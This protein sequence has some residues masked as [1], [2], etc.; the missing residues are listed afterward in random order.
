M[1]L[2]TAAEV[3][4]TDASTSVKH[5][6]AVQVVVHNHVDGE[7]GDGS[8]IDQVLITEAVAGEGELVRVVDVHEASMLL[9][10]A[11]NLLLTLLE[12]HLTVCKNDVGFR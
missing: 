7:V 2:T 3:V 12:A 10:Q 6:P 5:D 1:E 4:L 11:C 9:L 8:Y